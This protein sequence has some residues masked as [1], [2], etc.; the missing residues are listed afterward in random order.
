M[1]TRRASPDPSHSR[2]SSLSLSRLFRRAPR[3]RTRTRVSTLVRLRRRPR[4]TRS[5]LTRPLRSTLSFRACSLEAETQALIAKHE[6]ELT[7]A[8]RLRQDI[9]AKLGE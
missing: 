9:E 5:A 2:R 4:L 7:E 1:T 8:E 3:M 6:G